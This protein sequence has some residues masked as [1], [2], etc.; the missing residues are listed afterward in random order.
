MHHYLPSSTSV[1][2]LPSPLAAFNQA[3]KEFLFVTVLLVHSVLFT[4]PVTMSLVYCEIRAYHQLIRI[5]NFSSHLTTSALT[6]VSLL[7]FCI[8]T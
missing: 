5:I 8:T 7:A 2:F 6:V 3:E 1:L 4:L